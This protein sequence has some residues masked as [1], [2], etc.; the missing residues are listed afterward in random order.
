MKKARILLRV[1]SNQQLEADGDLGVQRQLV[2]EYI[3]KNP[4]W[5]LDEKEYFEGSNSGYSNAVEDRDVLQEALEDAK[6]GEY[7][8]LVAYKDDRI[9]RRMW[10]IGSYVMTMKSWNVDI[11]TVTDGCI[12]PGSDDVMGQMM[13]A[14][15]YG[16]A[17][18]S[19]SDTGKR[20]KDTAQKLVQRGKYM[21]GF[22]PYGYRLELSGEISK[23]GRAL[24]HL[25]I[26][27]EQAEA[28]R[29][30][31]ALSLNK[32]YG[33]VKIAKVLNRDTKYRKLA[34]RDVWKSGTIT[35]ILTNP[36]YA[37]YAAYKRR[38]KQNG[39]IKRLE[40]KEWVMAQEQNQE[41]TL[42]APEIW[43]KV[44]ERR[45]MRRKNFQVKEENE[46]ARVLAQNTGALPLLD[47]LYCGYC[48]KK[49]TNGSRYSYWTVKRTG[50][51]RAKKTAAYKC[52]GDCQGIPHPK[53]FVLNADQIEPIVFEVLAESIGLLQKKEDVFQH[54]IENHAKERK[55][56][57]GEVQKEKNKLHEIQKKIRILEEKI[58]DA[59][60]GEYPVSLEKLMQLVRQE[61]EKEKAQ[62]RYVLELTKSL[63][64][65]T[66]SAKEWEKL[67]KHIPTWQE[68]FLKADADVKRVLVNKL[69]DR[70]EVKSNDADKYI[71]IR[72]KVSLSEFLNQSVKTLVPNEQN[73]NLILDELQINVIESEK[74]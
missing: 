68:V 52:Q 56:K 24:H 40:S 27:E 15:R 29:Y 17:Q 58:P 42:V 50:E 65:M 38:E 23:H 26:A 28:V 32:E 73:R 33:S 35:S 11:Y 61:E 54:I 36:I 25:V 57:E 7:N 39:R 5:I 20:V 71:T 46:A 9:G 2:K 66:V 13:L 3:F 70:I 19:S 64:K 69:I 49:M 43:N 1:S 67:K 74:G 62:S 21:G 10:E 59:M 55:Y 22:A 51:R 14:L 12:S 6:K 30:I 31:F 44:Q 63:K 48:R 60:T 53:T 4:G 34:P 8:I 72:F 16:N 47:V 18:K 41:I 37:G 45:Q